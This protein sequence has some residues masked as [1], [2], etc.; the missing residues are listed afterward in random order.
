MS[1]LG[2]SYTAYS[3]EAR[4]K[5][6]RQAE[7]GQIFGPEWTP[8]LFEKSRH[9]VPVDQLS[10]VLFDGMYPYETAQ[11]L[12]WWFIA[13]THNLF[14]TRLVPYGVKYSAECER[15]PEIEDIAALKAYPK[16]QS[17]GGER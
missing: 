2:G 7:N 15:K 6:P 8:V 11:A 1:T 3:V 14:D 13:A 17:A 5:R 10:P 12:R 9:G 4:S 16:T